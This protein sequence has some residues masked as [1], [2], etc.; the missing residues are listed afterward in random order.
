MSVSFL[1]PENQCATPS[2]KDIENI[3]SNRRAAQPVTLA[4]RTSVEYSDT[5]D[6]VKRKVATYIFG[7]AVV[8][9][10]ADGE[11]STQFQVR[12]HLTRF[13]QQTLELTCGGKF[14]LGT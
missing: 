11:Q 1:P 7:T 6:G 13:R 8:I 2:L 12:N 10:R 3:H 14:I 5:T 4:H 9:L